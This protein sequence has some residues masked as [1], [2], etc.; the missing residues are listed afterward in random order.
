VQLNIPNDTN[1]SST[2]SEA[3]SGIQTCK[4]LYNATQF[5]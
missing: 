5:C 2:V 3:K 4:M 1:K